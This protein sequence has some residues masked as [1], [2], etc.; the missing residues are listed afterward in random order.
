MFA[1]VPPS[2]PSRLRGVSMAGFHDQ[3]PEPVVMRAVPHPAVNLSFDLSPGALLVDGG[4]GSRQG[5]L[6]AGPALGDLR[7]SGRGVEIVRVRLS[8]VVAYTVLGTSPAEVA[9]ALVD[10]DEL[11]G[12]DTAR[13]W[14][15]LRQARSWQDR[16]AL[17]DDLVARR[18]EAGREGRSVPHEVT[19]AWGLIVR[20]GGRIR[21]EAL[22][23]EIGW[24]R[25]RLWSRFRAHI[26][27]TPHRAAKLV[28]FHHAAHRLAGGQ[29][30]ARAAAD[31]GYYDQ[32]HLHRDVRAF[33]GDTP[34]A[35]A[36][37]P[38]LAVDDLA[39]PA[40]PR[41]REASRAMPARR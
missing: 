20:N 10:L 39:W 35:L 30:P 21:V 18:Y 6:V 19:R 17:T 22:A 32:S 31:S 13:L 5:N 28:R 8:P 14:E 29:S 4:T 36:G 11:W 23:A 3:G 7:V 12:R 37:E 27:L 9:G 38:L 41:D 34:V 40:G 26:G 2:R 15:R 1:L 25:K 24:S 16:F 33:T